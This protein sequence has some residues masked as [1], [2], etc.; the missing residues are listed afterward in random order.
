LWIKNK[1]KNNKNKID[2]L[3]CKVMFILYLICLYILNN[4]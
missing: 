4:K 1:N 2:F 3:I